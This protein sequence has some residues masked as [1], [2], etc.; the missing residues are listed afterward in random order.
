[1]MAADVK[2]GEEEGEFKMDVE[3]LQKSKDKLKMSFVVRGISPAYA[4]ALRRI[5]MHEVPT[6]AIEDVEFSKNSSILY[7][8]RIAHRLGLLP[9]LT[10][11][12]SYEMKKDCKC[13]GKGCARCQVSISLKAK[14]PCMVTAAAL[15]PK[16]PKI[17]PAYPEMPIVQL[18]KG[19]ELEFEAT[20][21]L[22]V[23]K[24]HAKWSPCLVWYTFEPDVKV[25]NN[26]SLFDEYKNKYPAA[27]F[28]K[29]G[30]LDKKLIMEHHLVDACAGVCDEVVQV[31]YNNNNFIFNIESWGQLDC[32]ELVEAAI[33]HFNKT[34]ADF[35]EKIKAL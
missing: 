25:N 6:L 1:M 15:K 13:E 18:L 29:S 19:Q 33:E 35:E 8:E 11:L 30:K 9:L 4:N 22:G 17:K 31:T 23:G 28:D 14:G 12:K 16:D 7:D 3:L 5:L 34:L 2:V 20:A 26:S 21:E 27:A 24:E 10:D 32:M